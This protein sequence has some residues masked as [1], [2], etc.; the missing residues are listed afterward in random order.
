M[1]AEMYE[2]TVAGRVDYEARKY[3]YENGGHT[4]YQDGLEYVRKTKPDLFRDYIFRS[5]SECERCGDI[6]VQRAIEYMGAHPGIELKDA[7]RK[8]FRDAPMLLKGY[9]QA[10]HR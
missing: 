10:D 2:Q 8:I 4:T 5:R 6:A 9:A 1:K 3:L 7:L